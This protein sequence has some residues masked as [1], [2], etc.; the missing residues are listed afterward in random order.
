MLL[1]E[2][3]FAANPSQVKEELEAIV[4]AENVRHF[5]GASD[6]L[7][8][9]KVRLSHEAS[10]ARFCGILQ[11]LCDAAGSLKAEFREGFY[12]LVTCGML[13]RA[14]PVQSPAAGRLLR[15]RRDR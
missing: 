2:L 12:S 3:P 14:P 9:R 8:A 7:K 15:G 6:L 4:C 13:K 5:P 11:F 1:K 10:I